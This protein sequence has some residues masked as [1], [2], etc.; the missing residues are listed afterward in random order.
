MKGKHRKD[1]FWEKYQNYF[2]GD[3]GQPDDSED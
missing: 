1:L 2:G 3:L